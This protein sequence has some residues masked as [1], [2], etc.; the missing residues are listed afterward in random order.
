VAI[1]LFGHCAYPIREAQ[2]R[3]DYIRAARPEWFS[4]ILH[5]ADAGD[6]GPFGH[7][8]ALEFGI[9]A[10]CRF[11]LFVHDK[12]RLDCLTDAV[13]FI[14]QVFGTDMLVMTYGMDS[15]RPPLQHYDAMVIE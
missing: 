4:A 8:I 5:L 10:R 11:G 6:L 14:Y 7:E 1:D 13:E 12:T 2:R 9:D 3:I 15:I